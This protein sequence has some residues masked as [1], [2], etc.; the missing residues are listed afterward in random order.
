MV[1]F[2]HFP[3]AK[4]KKERE[5]YQKTEEEAYYE[6][7]KLDQERNADILENLKEGWE[8]TSSGFKDWFNKTFPSS[9]PNKTAGKKAF[10]T[11]NTSYPISTN[12]NDYCILTFYNYDRFV[13]RANKEEIVTLNIQMPLPLNIPDTIQTNNNTA[14]LGVFGNITYDNFN[15]LVKSNSGENMGE[16][17]SSGLGRLTENIEQSSAKSA[18]KVGVALATSKFSDGGIKAAS[19]LHTGLILNPHTTAMFDGVAL[20][21]Y[22]LDWRLSPKTKEESDR[23]N[24]IFTAIKLRSLPGELAGGLS[25]NYPDTVQISFEGKVKSYFPGYQRSFLTSLSVNPDSNGGI[26]LYNSGAPVTYNLQLGF[27][28][29]NINTRSTIQ[30][31]MEEQ[32]RAKLKDLLDE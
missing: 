31:H 26:I 32:M 20:R 30:T 19:Q 12:L 4:I 18:M 28:E 14:D 6:Q 7:Q 5:E 1:G 10:T 25:L 2:H 9:D 24:E 29:L 15:N 17:L 23:L 13:S 16:H 3:Q 11:Y 22:N 21:S 8:E 27:I